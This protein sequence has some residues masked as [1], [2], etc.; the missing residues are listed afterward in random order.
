MTMT[1]GGTEM[2]HTSGAVADG[3]SA[4]TPAGTAGTPA[5]SKE[6]ALWLL[7]DLVPGAGVNNLTFTFQADGALDHEV[8]RQALTALVRRHEVLRTVFRATEGEGGSELLRGTVPAERAAVPLSHSRPGPG[9]DVLAELMAF[10]ATPFRADGSPL[11]RARHVQLPPGSGPVGDQS[12]GGQ[13]GGDVF[14]LVLHHS[15]YDGMST[16]VVVEEFRDLYDAFDSGE[17][18]PEQLTGEAPRW[19]EP[20]PDDRSREFW[21]RQVAGLTTSGLDLGNDRPL[22]ARTT[23]EGDWVTRRLDPAAAAVAKRLQRELRAPEVVVL[24]AGYFALLT[25]HGAGPDLTVGSPISVRGREQSRTVGYHIN[26]LTLRQSVAPERTFRDLATGLRTTFLD[27]VGHAGFPVD[28][29]LEIVPRADASW[30][31]TLFRHVFNYVPQ[32]DPR[33]TIGGGKARLVTVENGYSKFDLEFFVTESGDTLQIRAAFYRDAYDRADVELM[34]DRYEALLLAVGEDPDV[35][36]GELNAWSR[37]DRTVIDGANATEQEVPYPSVLHAVAEQAAAA[38]EAPAV[39]TDEATLS[40]G[41]LWADAQA[42]AA[43]LREAGAGPGAVVALLGRRG[44]ELAAAVLGVWL[45]GGVYLPLDPEHPHQRIAYQLDDADAR[46]VLAAEGVAVPEGGERTVLPLGGPGPEQSLDQALDQDPERALERALEL[47]LPEIDPDACA[48]LI[49]TSGSTGR[50]KGTLISHRN[51][52][53]LVSHFAEE[54]ACTPDTSTLWMTTFSFDISALELFVPLATGGLVVVAPDDARVD[55]GRLLEVLDRHS[56]DLVQATPTTWRL[57]V[58]QAGARLEGRKLLSGGEPLPP[59][60][61]R[62]LLATG[63]ELRNVYGP[64]ETTVWSASGR[65]DDLEEGGRLHVGGPI[66]NTRIF[67]ADPCGRE[68]PVGLRGELCI[69][70]TGVGIGYHERPDMTAERFADH[71]RYG[72]HYRTGDLARWLPDGTLEVLG[73]MDRQ[74]KLRGNRIELSEVESVLL[75]HP[76]VRAAAVVPVGDPTTDGALVAFV[77]PASEASDGAVSAAEASDGEASDAGLA[78]G[79]WAHS[80]ALLQGAAVP[81]DFIVVEAFP[82]TGNDKVDYPALV[83]AAIA[84]RAER[85]RGEEGTAA[86]GTGD[87]VVD[88]LT[89][90]WNDLLE[91]TGLDA[92]THFFTSGGHSLLGAKLLQ[93]ISKEIGVRLKLADLFANPTPRTLADQVRAHQG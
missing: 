24:L 70:G 68:L 11:L 77:V 75:E 30:R 57:V 83:R 82:M 19:T 15:V 37:C 42:V 33:F 39:R 38:P 29:L 79:L 93:R 55:G 71:P 3:T 27:A 92:D 4:R 45:A 54:L 53:N 5:S 69:A 26:V 46:F 18:T 6:R 16:G 67:V 64:T 41:E 58:Q 78:D 66:A 85:A 10:T 51:L 80:R 48:Y 88:A 81:Q 22:P 62:Q 91:T 13:V 35:T 63:G 2:E 73:R 72:R 61:A 36:L 86:G 25:S 87:E 1:T 47:P 28:E 50:P 14:C 84:R 52:A 34:I 21:Q 20:Q 74:V 31:N 60:L 17:P 23:L 40:Y 44:A 59:A 7:E 32:S 9:T 65:L 12:D 90:M 8:L 43:R 89:A 56:V 76:A 49:Y